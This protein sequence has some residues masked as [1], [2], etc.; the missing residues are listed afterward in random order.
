MVL[1]LGAFRA[2]ADAAAEKRERE[3]AAITWYAERLQ[4]RAFAALAEAVV[5]RRELEAR[6]AAVAQSVQLA[7]VREAFSGWRAAAA[8]STS[9]GQLVAAARRRFARGR[10]QLCF[11]AWRAQVEAERD[12]RRRLAACTQ[13]IAHL[14][15]GWA[16]HV[17]RQQAA[18]AAEERRLVARGQRCVARVRSLP[19][20]LDG[21]F[22]VL[23]TPVCSPALPSQRPSNRRI[24][25]VRLAAA[26]GGWQQHTAD[27]AAARQAAEGLAA[28]HNAALLHDCFVG[29]AEHAALRAE[30]QAAMVAMVERRAA[31]LQGTVLRFWRALVQ[32]ERQRRAQ[33]QR[34]VRKLSLLRQQQVWRAWRGAV[35]ERQAED[36]RLALAERRLTVRHSQRSLAAAFTAWR[37]HTATL[38][39]ARAAVEAKVAAEGAVVRRHVLAAW[40]GATEAVAQRRD[41]LLR[42]CVERRATALQ[43][44]ALFA[45]QL[46]AQVRLR[47]GTGTEV[48]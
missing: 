34:A 16:L 29:W 42:V 40:L 19:C 24:T 9:E 45:L 33:L 10:L 46:H 5:R 38:A 25:R 2:N 14:R 36:A 32:H 6:L 1:A 26:F 35:A 3:L 44:K 12:Q 7:A 15:L 22:A 4:A 28:A 43:S 11:A 48:H 37:G 27:L 13:R 31:W 18:T 20:S 17:W 30:Q 23:L 47:W 21:P 41:H 39:A 8:L